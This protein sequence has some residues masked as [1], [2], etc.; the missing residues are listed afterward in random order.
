MI[1]DTE[2]LYNRI[3]VH[4]Y[5][6]NNLLIAKIVRGIF[7]GNVGRFKVTSNNRNITGAVYIKSQTRAH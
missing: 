5:V 3:S 7:Q 1:S 2:F 6:F 4:A